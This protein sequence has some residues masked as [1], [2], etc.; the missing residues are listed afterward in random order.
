M[1]SQSDAA[2]LLRRVGFGPT[3]AEITALAAQP[4][5]EAAVDTVLNTGGQPAVVKPAAVGGDSNYEGWVAALEWWLQRMVT[6]P[7]PVVEKMV[8][9][10]HGHFATSN[11]KVT[12]MQLM[13][14]QQELFRTAGLGNFRDLV[15]NMSIGP[16]MLIY[17]DNET[18]EVGAEQ[19]N[20]GRE[21]ME[22]FT[23]GIGNY[24]EADVVSMAR[25]WTGTTPS[26]G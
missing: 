16:A 12:D 9:F 22:L 26:A 6:T 5:R 11:D 2:H 14:D 20:F 23:C 18:N 10:W 8:L 24:T 3:A 25:A 19:E 7:V 17:L 13:W 1:I 21:L 15:W 4:T